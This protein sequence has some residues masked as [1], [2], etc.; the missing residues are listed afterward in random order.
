M[1]DYEASTL[2]FSEEPTSVK[3]CNEGIT[4]WEGTVAE[5]GELLT[6]LQ[7]GQL[8]EQID[9][10]DLLDSQEEYMVIRSVP[11]SPDE[12]VCHVRPVGQGGM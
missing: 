7:T 3:V 1:I 5:Y 8:Y 10:N 6:K 12:F 9:P 4:V 2:R 11:D